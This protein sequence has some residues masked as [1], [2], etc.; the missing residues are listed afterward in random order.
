MLFTVN[1]GMSL[2][3][4]KV[5]AACRNQMSVASVVRRSAVLDGRTVCVK[6]WA[7]PVSAPTS[8]GRTRFISELF[9]VGSQQ[10]KK[11]KNSAIG[12]VEGSES[13]QFEYNPD[14]FRKLD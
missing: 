8:A 11:A 2:A 13:A 7:F 10:S 12:L 4:C 6:G 5:Q 9:P 14:S 1:L 3:I